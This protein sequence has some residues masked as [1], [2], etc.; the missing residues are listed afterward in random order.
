MRRHKKLLKRGRGLVELDNERRH[1]ARIAAKKVRYAT[2]FF[3]SLFSRRAVKHYI[4]A[5]SELQDDL[6]WRNDI[7]VADGL[8][9]S[10]TA[11]KPETASGAA[12]ARGYFASRAAQDR[13]SLKSLWKRFSRLTPPQC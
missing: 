5:L 1:R 4:S 10:L 7:V 11:S 8:L 13:D 9:K 6:G 12:F 3:S 2:E